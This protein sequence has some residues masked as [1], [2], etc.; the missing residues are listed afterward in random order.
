MTPK[1]SSCGALNLFELH[2]LAVNGAQFRMGSIQCRMC[3]AVVGVVDFYNIGAMLKKQ[4][5]AIKK[6]AQ[7]VGVHVDL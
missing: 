7:K 1:C 2:E 3:G 4:N 5:E 6:I